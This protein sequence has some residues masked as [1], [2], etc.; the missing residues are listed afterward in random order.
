MWTWKCRRFNLGPENV[1]YSIRWDGKDSVLWG[2]DYMIH[3]SELRASPGNPTWRST[4]GK[5]PFVWKKPPQ[6][7]GLA[8]K[9]ARLAGGPAVVVCPTVSRK[10]LPVVETM[11]EVGAGAAAAKLLRRLQA[12]EAVPLE[13]Q[14]EVARHAAPPP[15]G[16]TAAPRA[17][18]AAAVK[19]AATSEEAPEVQG[20]SATLRE[21]LS[22][23]PPPP[24]MSPREAE[25]IEVVDLPPC[26]GC[27]VQALFDN[28]WHF[29]TVR[30]L[31]S[32]GRL[33]VLWES[34][35][36]CSI[37]ASAELRRIR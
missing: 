25:F 8:A 35:R 17:P 11:D 6:A 27:R 12:H 28:D 15:P 4:C 5:S 1:T 37:F 36:S 2:T 19:A 9:L 23:R 29:A 26:V 34:E 7:Q 32:D 21:V 31:L 33:E 3:L 22:G 16:L 24:R 13:F 14:S 18:P 10:P 30:R 20:R